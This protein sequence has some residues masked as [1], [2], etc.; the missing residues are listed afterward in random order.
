MGAFRAAP[1]LEVEASLA[2]F[3]GARLVVF[4]Q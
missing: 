2:A 1:Q 3:Y 4:E